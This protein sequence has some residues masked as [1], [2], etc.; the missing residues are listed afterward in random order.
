V[1]I[2]S[3]PSL[4]PV[5]ADLVALCLAGDEARSRQRGAAIG[6]QSYASSKRALTQWV[7]RT[8]VQPGWADRG[9]L[10]NGIAPGIVN[11]P[12][13]SPLLATA[14]GRTMLAQGVPRAVSDFAEAMDV[15]LL[16]AFLASEHNRYLVGQV[17]F[18]DGGSDVLL[19]GEEPL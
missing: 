19:R 17:P 1:V 5:D 12:M 13:V 11:T 6:E 4:H 8:A 2:S 16:L 18:C 15:A 10:L 9:V 14:E 3:L 7:R